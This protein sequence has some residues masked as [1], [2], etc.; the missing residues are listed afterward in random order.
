MP[1]SWT[2]LRADRL[3]EG[4]AW[5]DGR[6][7]G[8]VSQG[9]LV[10]TLLWVLSGW[11]LYAVDASS[12]DQDATCPSD[13]RFMEPSRGLM[14]VGCGTRLEPFG[15]RP[16]GGPSGL[17]FG[18]PLDLNVAVARDL[19]VIPGIGESR[20]Q[21]IVEGRQSRPYQSVDDLM[22]AHGIGRVTLARVRGWVEVEK[23]LARRASAQ[24]DPPGR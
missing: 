15:T 7:S 21:A 2:V 11:A 3:S 23:G 14:R 18:R 20:A 4:L 6:M 12:P 22:R 1:S 13:D 16:L 9:I 17:L 24:G 10:M 19:M 8:P 5:C